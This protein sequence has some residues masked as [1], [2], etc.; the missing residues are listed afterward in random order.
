[1]GSARPHSADSGGAADGDIPVTSD[2]DDKSHAD[3]ALIADAITR[4]LFSAGYDLY[5]VLAMTGDG[6]ART[7]LEHA[8][9]ELDGAL[10]DVRRLM[11]TIWEHGMP[12]SETWATADGNQRVRSDG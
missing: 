2:G 9:D 7:R 4:R 5:F 11:I 12:Q 10:R 6:P 3:T 1:M 8:V